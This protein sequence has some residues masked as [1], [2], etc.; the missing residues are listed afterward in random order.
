MKSTTERNGRVPAGSET[1]RAISSATRR[2]SASAGV[3][4]A[5][6]APTWSISPS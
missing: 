5:S 3:S 1:M 6:L 2:G 4:A